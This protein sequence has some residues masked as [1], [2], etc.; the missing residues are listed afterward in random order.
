M[1]SWEDGLVAQKSQNLFEEFSIF[2][3][4][5]EEL[6]NVAKYLRKYLILRGGVRSG[7]ILLWQFIDVFLETLNLVS[8]SLEKDQHIKESL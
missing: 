2:T 3:V 4:F 6:G 7:V 8:R 5:R 1:Q